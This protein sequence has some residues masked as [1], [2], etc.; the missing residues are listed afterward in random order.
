MMP[1]EVITLP[2][3]TRCLVKLSRRPPKKCACGRPATKL[4][5]FEV[6]PGHGHLAAKTCDKPLY[7]KCAVH[8]EK[9]TDYCPD[10][11]LPVGAQLPLEGL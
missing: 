6:E 1:C 2:D 11:P 7:T 4:C 9:D 10:H 3:G 8:V 5:D